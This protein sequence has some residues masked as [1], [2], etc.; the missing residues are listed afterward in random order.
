MHSHKHQRN[1]H[2]DADQTQYTGVLMN[3]RR[4]YRHKLNHGHM[5][6]AQ[7]FLRIESNFKTIQLPFQIHYKKKNNGLGKVQCHSKLLNKSLKRCQYLRALTVKETVL[8]PMRYLA[9]SNRE[10]C[11][12]WFRKSWTIEAIFC[13]SLKKTSPVTKHP[14]HLIKVLKRK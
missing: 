11:H 9:N 2:V 1:Y 6:W 12:N 10:T 4:C 3:L 8:L 13:T 7:I 5:L 14:E